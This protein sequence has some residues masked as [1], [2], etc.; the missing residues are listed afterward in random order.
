MA[1]DLLTYEKSYAYLKYNAEVFYVTICTHTHTHTH[2]HA[3]PYACAAWRLALREKCR[4][5]LF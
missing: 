1:A 4:L 3:V 2:T 5:C